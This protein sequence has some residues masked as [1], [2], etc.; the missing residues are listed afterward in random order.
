MD[1][2]AHLIPQDSF[3]P[4]KPDVEKI[5]RRLSFEPRQ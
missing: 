5:D 3:D 2:F 4:I 1:E